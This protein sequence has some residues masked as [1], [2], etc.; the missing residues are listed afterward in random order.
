MAHPF[1]VI[2]PFIIIQHSRS[3]AIMAAN[4]TKAPKPEAPGPAASTTGKQKASARTPSLDNLTFNP[5]TTRPDI[6]KPVDTAGRRHE[7]TLSLRKL[8]GGVSHME[9][10][11][12]M[13]NNGRFYNRG[14]DKVI[15]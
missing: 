15:V 8:D 11:G 1:F 5:G 12:E 3:Q 13:L 10:V 4:S 9:K 7:G 14:F 2:L 6:G